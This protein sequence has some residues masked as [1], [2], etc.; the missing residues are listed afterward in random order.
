MRVTGTVAD[1]AE[2]FGKLTVQ[3]KGHSIVNNVMCSISESER[4]AAA[5]LEK[6][7]TATVVGRGDGK[8]LGLYSGLKDC[9]V[10]E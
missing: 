5:K 8:T 4:A 1:V 2:T 9:K 10:I 7:K 6:G 3:L